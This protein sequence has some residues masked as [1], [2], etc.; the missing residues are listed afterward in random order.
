LIDRYLAS[1][2]IAVGA[3]TT[4]HVDYYLERTRPSQVTEAATRPSLLSFLDEVR[5]VSG[6]W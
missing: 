6:L 3:I 4:T 1:I 5:H 2:R